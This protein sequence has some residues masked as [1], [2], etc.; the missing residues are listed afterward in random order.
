MALTQLT[1]PYPNPNNPNPNHFSSFQTRAKFA[2][3]LSL[4]SEDPQQP[5]TWTLQPWEGEPAM[6]EAAATMLDAAVLQRTVSDACEPYAC[7]FGR[8]GSIC[9]A[10]HTSFQAPRLD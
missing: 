6:A 3:A 4:H 1:L 2:L 7:G 10:I 9:G 8:L 5:L